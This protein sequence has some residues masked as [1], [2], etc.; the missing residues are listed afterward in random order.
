MAIAG[1][2]LGIRLPLITGGI[3][4]RDLER[5]C[6][7]AG[8]LGFGSIWMGD[9][10]VPPTA[11]VDPYPYTEDHQTP[12]HP[13]SPWL[14]P[15]IT[16]TWLSRSM[17]PNMRLGTSIYLLPLRNETLVA[18][19]IGTLSWLSERP[20]S[21]GVGSGWFRTEYDIIGVNFE[22]RASR[23]R[24]QI[25]RLR[26]LL[27]TGV[28]PDEYLDSPAPLRPLPI[29][30]TEFLWGGVSPLGLRIVAEHC[31]GWLPTKCSLEELTSHIG[32]LKQCCDEAGRDFE[33]LRLVAKPGPGPYPEAGAVN[34]RSLQQ[35]RELGFDEVILEL[36]LNP[37]SSGDCLKIMEHVTSTCG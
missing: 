11:A 12:A 18:K 23:A 6:T 31:D 37:A 20:F 33:E 10:V 36:P 7:V 9:H 14:D 30:H 34:A 28:L 2:E 8:E 22:R 32:T 16:L 1:M 19:L 24:A 5:I 13:D 26:E 15:F 4:P 29:H 35:Y 3:E 25:D 27:D 21:F 17:G